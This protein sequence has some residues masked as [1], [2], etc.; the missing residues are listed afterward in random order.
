M[1]LSMKPTGFR[2]IYSNDLSLTDRAASREQQAMFVRDLSTAAANIHQECVRAGH[3][4]SSAGRSDYY[5]LHH[6]K[7]L[8]IVSRRNP[9]LS[10]R[11]PVHRIVLVNT[12]VDCLARTADEFQ[13]PYEPAKLSFAR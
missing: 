10:L 3:S 9:N 1:P 12:Q 2:A 6:G 4:I 7:G 8:A 13:L 11:A 5:I